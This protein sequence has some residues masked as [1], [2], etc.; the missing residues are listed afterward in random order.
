MR[1]LRTSARRCHPVESVGVYAG[2]V[3]ATRTGAYPELVIRDA[4][5]R[6]SPRRSLPTISWGAS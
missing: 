2:V 1:L 6:K 3:P 4:D 5:G